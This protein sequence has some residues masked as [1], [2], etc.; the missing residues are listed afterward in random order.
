MGEVFYWLFNMSVAASLAGTVIAL[1]RRFWRIPRR[2]AVILWII[3]F[4]RFWF[5]FGIGSRYSLMTLLSR[6]TTRTV[7]VYEGKLASFSVMNSVMAANSYFPITYKVDLL[8]DV[9]EIAA[10]V[11]AILAGAIVITMAVLCFTTLSELKTADRLRDH[12]YLSNKVTSP[13][14]YGIFRPR[15]VIPASVSDS[16]DLDLI[17]LH[18]ERHIRRLDNLWR[19]AAF[20]T[21]S[22]HWFNPLAWLFL[23]LFLSD[24][25]LACDESALARLPADGK[26][27]YAHAL[28]N[29]EE[30]KT[31]FASAFGGAKIRTRIE[32]VLSFRRMTAVSAVGSAVL[33]AVIAY[34]LL[35]NA[36]Q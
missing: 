33:A 11:W 3:P 36:A 23:K 19:I 12:V 17:L 9:F 4:L 13:A 5:P 7:T 25:E 29:A 15:I 1:V 34:V 28:L 8:G 2:V 27:R 10:V 20:L 14:V 30:S 18:E 22:L 31:L 6:F 21:A 32:H 16:A 35:T 26:K 24:L